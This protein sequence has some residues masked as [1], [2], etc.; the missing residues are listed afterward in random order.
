M[1]VRYKDRFYIA[2]II[3]SEDKN[4]ANTSQRLDY[5]KVNTVFLMRSAIWI[6]APSNAVCYELR[7]RYA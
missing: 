6:M 7:Y 1:K 5:W 3:S 4:H 2:K